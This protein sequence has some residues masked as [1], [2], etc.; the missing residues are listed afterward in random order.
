MQLHVYTPM[1]LP[2]DSTVDTWIRLLRARD[3]A[4]AAAEKALKD[5]GFP[6]PA[7]YD[8]LL[9]L[10]QAGANGLRPFELQAALFLP[11]YGVS[12]LIERIGKAGYLQRHGCAKDRRGQVLTITPAGRRL[13]RTMW[14]VYGAAIEQ[15][16]G[17]KVTAGEMRLLHRVLGKLLPAEL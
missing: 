17:A 2:T 1:T 11:Q 8:A 4:F 6:P 10:E 16:V 5:D 12:R 7:W 9:E 15:A 13:R 3:A 14:P